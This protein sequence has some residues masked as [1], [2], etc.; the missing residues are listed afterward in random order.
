MAIINFSSIQV[1]LVGTAFAW[2]FENYEVCGIECGKVNLAL[3][4]VS[5]GNETA[6][7]EWP[8]IAALYDLRST[9]YICGGTLISNKHVLTGNDERI[10]KSLAFKRK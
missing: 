7:S 2:L 6:R 1:I 4:L 10:V 9:E 8:F 5:G 3:P